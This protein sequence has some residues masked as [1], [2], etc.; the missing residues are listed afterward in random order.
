MDRISDCAK[1]LLVSYPNKEQ[2][3]IR[4]IPHCI[5]QVRCTVHTDCRRVSRIWCPTH[6]SLTF[7]GPWIISQSLLR[8][9]SRAEFWIQKKMFLNLKLLHTIRHFFL[10]PDEE[11][12]QS[13]NPAPTFLCSFL[14]ACD[15]RLLL[16][17]C[18][19][20]HSNCV[21][22]GNCQFS[23]LRDPFQSTLSYDGRTA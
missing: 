18:L 14:L 16:L 5:I 2:Q 4:F 20:N 8:M 19:M 9:T 6:N 3:M 23:I 15:L 12:R 1:F 13:W 17:A 11:Q 7:L 22:N 10:K 21:S